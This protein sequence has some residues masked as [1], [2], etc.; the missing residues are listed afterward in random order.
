MVIGEEMPDAV[1]AVERAA[2]HM[3]QTQARFAILDNVAK[4]RWQVVR[5]WSQRSHYIP[6]LGGA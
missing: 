4:C 5:G 6:Q 2:H 1:A 3:V